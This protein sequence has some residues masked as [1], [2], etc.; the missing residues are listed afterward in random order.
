VSLVHIAIRDGQRAQLH[1]T[2]RIRETGFERIGCPDHSALNG[3]IR[4][5]RIGVDIHIYVLDK[6][7]GTALGVKTHTYDSS[8]A[9][10]HRID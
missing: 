4:A 8:I 1:G 2:E 9:R 5:K 10:S 6:P 7:S 3:E